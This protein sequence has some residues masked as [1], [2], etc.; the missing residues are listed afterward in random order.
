MLGDWRLGDLWGPLVVGICI[1]AVELADC[2]LVG[3]GGGWDS[4][5]GWV[6]FWVSWF[7]G[8]SWFVFWFGCL[9][10]VVCLGFVLIYYNMGW[11]EFGLLLAVGWL[12]WW[13]FWICS[14]VWFE[15]CFVGWCGFNGLG[16]VRL[17]RDCGRVAT[18]RIWF[19]S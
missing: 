1:V 15:F 11:H 10:L 16:C 9:A 4:D 14:M 18:L 17:V 6:D 13:V 7:C 2:C 12:F 19:D 8:F 5:C 3:F